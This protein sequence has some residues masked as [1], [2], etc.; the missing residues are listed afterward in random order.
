MKDS[1][2]GSV[3]PKN[4]SI[5]VDVNLLGEWSSEQARLR[6]EIVRFA[7][8]LGGSLVVGLT[9][10]PLLFLNAGR[11]ASANAGLRVRTAALDSALAVADRQRKAAQP[12]LVVGPMVDRTSGSFGR[13]L[14][15][16][17]R[18]L[19]AGNSR[20]AIAS[21]RF[22]VNGGELHAVLQADAE[23]EGAIDAFVRSVGQE[24]AT[25]DAITNARPSALLSPQ[26]TAFT[27]EKRIKVSP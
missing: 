2:F 20:I 22:E 15:A 10:T 8:L 25:V 9:V 12:A 13:M 4:R 18:V 6:Q 14:G 5:N 1:T 16:V 17:D 23:D 3:A 26:G 27:Y 21:A 7:A 24:E 11:S 19:G